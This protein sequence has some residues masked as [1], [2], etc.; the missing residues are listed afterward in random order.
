ME[1]DKRLP[2]GEWNGFYLESHQPRR[3]WMH[4]YMSYENGKIKGEGTDYVGPWTAAGNYDLHTGVCSWIKRYVG[5]HHV[6]SQGIC[7]SN[8]IQ[9]QWRIG[10]FAKGEF[11]IWPKSMHHL[12]ELYLHEDLNQ[13]IPSTLLGSVPAGDFLPI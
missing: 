5:K 4:L 6:E 10:P 1:L 7:G 11:H 13:T 2:T 3:G 8:G 9:G 12:N